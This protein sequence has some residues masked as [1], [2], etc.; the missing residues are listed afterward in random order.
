MNFTYLDTSYPIKIEKKKNKNAY[1]RIKDNCIYVIVPIYYTSSMIEKLIL[2]NK[3]SIYH[4]LEKSQNRNCMNDGFW[5]LGVRY[6]I[7]VT[8]LYDLEFMGSKVYVSSK[9]VLDKFVLKEAKHLFLERL[10]YWYSIFDENIP[11][12]TL[13]IRCMKTRWGVCNRRNNT[14]TLNLDL[15]KY[16][17]DKLDYVIIHELSHFVHFDHSKEFWNVVFKYCPNYKKI[18]KELK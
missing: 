4:M 5:Y 10:E 8:P 15:M 12:P 14:V 16:S 2:E 18:R 9:S 1:I 13:K 7:I 11:H 17:L 6:D 3:S